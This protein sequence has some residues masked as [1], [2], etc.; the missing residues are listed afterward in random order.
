MRFIAA[1]ALVGGLSSLAATSDPN[2]W[3][4][5]LS[6]PRVDAWVAEQNKLTL[7][8]LTAD[9][10][11]APLRA[12]F[13]DELTAKDRLSYVTVVGPHLYNFWQDATHIR[14]IWRR[15]S[16]AS[17]GSADTKW[18]AVIDLDRLDAAEHATGC[19]WA[20]TARPQ[21][22]RAALSDC[23]T[24]AKMRRPGANLICRRRAS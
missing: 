24:A 13:I 2:L 18:E 16:L 11:F 10:R 3:L 12:K 14:G 21:L 6:S 4:E 19:G 8:T 5:E 1:L 23:R 22:T 20:R 9:P 7:A 15:T 17:Y